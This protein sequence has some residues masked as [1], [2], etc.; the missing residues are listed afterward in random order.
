MSSDDEEEVTAMNSVMRRAMAP[1]FPRRAT[2][3]K[4]A[5]NP[6]E[7]C[8]VVMLFGYVGYAGL[9]VRATAESPK[10]VANPKGIANQAIPPII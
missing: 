6:E 2:V 5:D 7:T 4:G 1:G 3:A 10:V 8:D 9:D